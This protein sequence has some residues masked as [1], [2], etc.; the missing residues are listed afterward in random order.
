M[1]KE[2]NTKLYNE[3]TEHLI[4][5]DTPS[6]YLN[7]LSNGAEFKE[8][9]LKLLNDLKKTEQSPKYHPE[10]NVWNH[11]MLVVDEAAKVRDESNDKKAFMWSALLHDIGKPDTTRMRK[12]RITSYDH[13][14]V[15]GK[16]SIDFLDVYT[17]DIEFKLKV[18]A[19]VRY[20]MHMLYVLKKLPFADMKNLLRKVDI[21]DMAL[22][23]KCDRLGRTGA[24]T[25]EEEASYH[26]YLGKLKTAIEKER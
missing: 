20:H 5:D 1:I 13:D 11:T 15:G 26:E 17:D 8:Y 25:E 12:G 14:K 2:N 7:K 22:L 3:I 18:G 4:N 9:P 10:G 19:L 24:N 23:S 21:E 6:Q 16:L